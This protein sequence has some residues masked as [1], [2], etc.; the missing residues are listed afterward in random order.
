MKL[1]EVYKQA[2]ELLNERHHPMTKIEIKCWVYHSESRVR[3][4]NE[5]FTFNNYTHCLDMHTYMTY[6]NSGLID[7][8]DIGGKE[9]AQKVV[10]QWFS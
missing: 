9:E 8:S 6:I 7:C 2:E 5:P 10:Q 4:N 3:N 1:E